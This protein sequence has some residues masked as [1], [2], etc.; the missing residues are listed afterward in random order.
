MTDCYAFCSGRI[1][2]HFTRKATGFCGSQVLL[3][4]SKDMRIC[5]QVL[6]SELYFKFFPSPHQS[7]QQLVWKI[8]LLRICLAIY[9]CLV[10]APHYTAPTYFGKRWL[11]CTEWAYSE[12]SLSAGLPFPFHS[13]T[14][15]QVPSSCI[16]RQG[17]RDKGFI[18]LIWRDNGL[19]SWVLCLSVTPRW[20]EYYKHARWNTE[21]SFY[22]KWWWWGNPRE[23]V[24]FICEIYIYILS[25]SIYMTAWYFEAS[26][27]LNSL[28]RQSLSSSL[29]HT[30]AFVSHIH[31]CDGFSLLKF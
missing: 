19:S 24:P 18:Y 30:T 12:A 20:Q 29:S 5:L 8:L 17:Q 21:Q 3:T 27:K 10:R 15:S 25:L 6:Y 16:K 1:G 28:C 14:G 2:A 4:V 22:V 7:T 13:F 9:S 31:T 26:R 23:S 11:Q